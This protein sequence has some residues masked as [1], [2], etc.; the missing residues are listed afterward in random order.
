MS[1]VNITPSADLYQA[2]TTTPDNLKKPSTL[3]IRNQLKFILIHLFHTLYLDI[4]IATLES[5]PFP[6]S[7]TSL[8]P[9]SAYLSITASSKDPSHTLHI[10][11]PLLVS[12]LPSQYHN[13]HSIHRLCYY[14]SKKTPPHRPTS[15]AQRLLRKP[16]T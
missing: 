3:V 7:A 9:P 11:I 15:P 10:T 6:H 5:P 2:L 16:P 8:L 1:S 13:H 14:H 4:Q 12:P